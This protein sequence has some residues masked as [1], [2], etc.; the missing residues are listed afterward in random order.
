MIIC[1]TYSMR[2]RTV[3]LTED[4]DKKL[5]KLVKNS[6]LNAS[7]IMRL[8]LQKLYENELDK[9][10]EEAYKAYY[11]TTDTESNE[12]TAEF[13]SASASLW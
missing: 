12:I 8:A 5:E 4:D 3:T 2:R 9:N 7:K 10:M 13:S 6:K 11:E 1:H